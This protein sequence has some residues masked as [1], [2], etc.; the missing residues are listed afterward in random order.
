MLMSIPV[1]EKIGKRARGRPPGQEFP[2]SVQ[3]RLSQEQADALDLWCRERED[4]GKRSEA[5]RFI[6]RDWLTGHGYLRHRDDPEGA[7]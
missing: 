1:N 6:L 7:N 5:I 4:G 2:V 3:L